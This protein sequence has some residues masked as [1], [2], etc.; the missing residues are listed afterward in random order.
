M[1]LGVSDVLVTDYSSIFYDFLATGRP[2]LFFV[3]DLAR[4]TER[5]RAVPA[6]RRSWPGPVSATFAEH[7]GHLGDGASGTHAVPPARREPPREYCPHDDGHGLRA[8]WWTSSSAADEAE[9][10]A[11]VDDFGDGREKILIYLGGMRTTGSP[12]RR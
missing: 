2:V 7:L 3:P 10:H 1:A 5:P 11:Y 6:P 8:A 12:H 4:T 9:E